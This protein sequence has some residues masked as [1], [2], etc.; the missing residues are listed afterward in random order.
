MT[1][2]SLEPPGDHLFI[3]ALGENGIR[4]GERW[5]TGAFI[6]GRQHVQTDW[7]PQ[8]LDQLSE[9]HF[10]PILEL[11]PELVLLGTGSRQGLVSPALLR[12]F[13][14]AGVGIEVMTTDAACRT[15]NLLAAEDR[16]VV[17]A[18]LP[19]DEQRTG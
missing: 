3:R 12:S 14:A 6:I 1:D 10:G 4:V 13:Y 9:A 19:L 17:A 16:E 15:F 2:L 5:I 18:L 8:T 7:P 11:K